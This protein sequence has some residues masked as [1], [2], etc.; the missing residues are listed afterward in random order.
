MSLVGLQAGE[1]GQGDDEEES[2]S[3]AEIKAL[4]ARHDQHLA[5]TRRANDLK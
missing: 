4:K 3:R 2:L 1:I 5:A